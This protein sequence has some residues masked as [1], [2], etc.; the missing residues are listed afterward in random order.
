M[1]IRFIAPDP[2]E[3][4]DPILGNVLASGTDQVA[5]ACAFF[6]NGGMEFLRPYA[7]RLRLGPSFFVA[8]W[9]EPTSQAALTELHSLAPGK[10][11]VHLGLESPVER[12]V[13]PGLMHSKV[14]F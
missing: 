7:A 10:V 14:L 1:N 13:G 4:A 8:S 3:V 11:Y 9:E 12:K 5:I 6:T 2:Q